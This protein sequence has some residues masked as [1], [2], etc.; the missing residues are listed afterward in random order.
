MLCMA[1]GLREFGCQELFNH[2]EEKP[3]SN[4]QHAR[5]PSDNSNEIES[6]SFVC[7]ENI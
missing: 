3:I 4:L 6:L 5:F 2:F 7:V 1:V